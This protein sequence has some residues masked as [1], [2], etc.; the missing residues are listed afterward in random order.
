MQE[1]LLF[2]QHH[3]MLNT[4]ILRGFIRSNRILEFIHQKGNATKASPAAGDPTNKSPQS[5]P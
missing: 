1:I 4:G 3:W 5:Y 2:I